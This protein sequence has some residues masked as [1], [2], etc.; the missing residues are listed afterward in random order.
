MNS[1]CPSPPGDG[2]PWSFGGDESPPVPGILV[3]GAFGKGEDVGQVT[4][5]RMRRGLHFGSAT[6]FWE[7]QQLRLLDTNGR[8]LSRAYLVHETIHFYSRTIDGELP[9][10]A[11]HG[12]YDAG[13]FNATVADHPEGGTLV[14]VE[15]ERVLWT[16]HAPR[17]RPIVHSFRCEPHATG[18]RLTWDDEVGSDA[19]YRAVVEY[20]ITDGRRWEEVVADSPARPLIDE[21]T[22]SMP[23]GHC[24]VDFD[25]VPPGDVLLRV[26]VWDGFHAARSEVVSVTMPPRALEIEASEPTP[27]AMLPP[28]GGYSASATA[29][30]CRSA[31][32]TEPGAY[33]WRLDG[34]I[35][36]KGDYH[37]FP[38]PE[39][40]EHE[41]ALTVRWRGVEERRS[42]RFA[43]TDDVS[44]QLAA[45]AAEFQRQLA[46]LRGRA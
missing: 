42:F 40:G 46:R 10:G 29:F 14:I 16:R 8:E 30:I 4:V 2:F 32:L 38:C 7:P 19:S 3:E 43:V 5:R 27:S 36:G 9:P 25:A 31:P 6:R 15:G 44:T 12:A 23:R 18:V 35:V 20:S 24:D 17:P 33:E 41:L 28:S 39:V 1:N 13:T 37:C 34:E 26:V 22:E 45:G 11:L 21:E